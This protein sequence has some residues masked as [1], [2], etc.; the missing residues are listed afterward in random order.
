MPVYGNAGTYNVQINP[1]AQHQQTDGIIYK[2]LYS[3]LGGFEEVCDS[4][5]NYTVRALRPKLMIFLT[6]SSV[7]RAQSTHNMT[8]ACGVSTA[9]TGAHLDIHL[10]S[11]IVRSPSQTI[12]TATHRFASSYEELFFSSQILFLPIILNIYHAARG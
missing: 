4:W 1:F 2:P 7:S 11:P 3:L 5:I 6:Y 12:V 8:G 9:M 10:R